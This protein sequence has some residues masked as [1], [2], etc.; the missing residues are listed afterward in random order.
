VVF[1]V[2]VYFVQLVGEVAAQTG[3]ADLQVAVE[4]GPPAVFEDRAV[5][6]FDMALGL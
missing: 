4:G 1:A 3:E 5:Q 6:S 2:E